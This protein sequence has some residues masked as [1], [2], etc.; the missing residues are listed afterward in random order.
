[1]DGSSGN[2]RLTAETDTVRRPLVSRSFELGDVSFGAVLNGTEQARVQWATPGGFEAAGCGVATT[3]AATGPDRFQTIQQTATEAFA[4]V[5]H[6]GPAESRPRAFGGLSFHDTHDPAWPW[7]GFDGAWFVVPHVQIT[8]GDAGTWLTI[9][10]D[11]EAAVAD[12]STRWQAHLE[13]APTMR[14]SGH[15]PGI[16]ESK[17]TT[18]REEWIQGV[19]QALEQI[20]RGE[21]EKVVLAQALSAELESPIDVP[22][23]LE[24]LRRQYA[25]CYRF[26]VDPGTDAAGTFFGAP[27]ERLLSMHG[28][29]LETE[30]LAGSVPRG[31][32]L[33]ED[34][35]YA[36]TM[37]ESHKVQHE[38]GLVVKTIREQL[39]PL[40]EVLTGKQTTRQLATIQ[41]LQ[42]PITATLAED[43]HI[44]E[45]VDALHPTPAVGGLPPAVAWE[46]IRSIEPF[47]RGWYA[48][49][50]GW[51]DA[52][53]DGEF[54][55]AIR[56]GVAT[57]KT[58]TLFAGNGIVADS[59]PADEW[60]EA[61][62]KFRPIL[63]ELR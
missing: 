8:R 9:T 2:E 17:Q 1:M 12:S 51:F 43:T 52:E 35:A 13:Q 31:E 18:T 39:R 36:K 5:D 29:A 57:G 49:P 54:A 3:F 30:A 48:A 41:H 42:T 16:V 46:T 23:T 27:P 61:Q 62:L 58:V 15:R 6:D 28:A 22:A 10:G 7:E 38:H 32:T 47:D 53:G 34:E 45:I 11:D 37:R 19:K 4:G 33:E 40:G 24:R 44:L 25:N 63:D 56:S 59:D 21:L 55:V 60:E 26:L 20:D 14:P 50:V